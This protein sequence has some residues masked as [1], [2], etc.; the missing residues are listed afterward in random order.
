MALPEGYEHKD[1]QKCFEQAIREGRLSAD[2]EAVNFAGKY[3]Y[4]GTYHGKDTFKH[5]D[6]RKYDV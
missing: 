1:A 5:Y 2:P 3:M 6:S 4:M